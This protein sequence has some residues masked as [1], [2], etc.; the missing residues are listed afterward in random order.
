MMCLNC[1]SINDHG[2]RYEEELCRKLDEVGIKPGK[3]RMKMR[4]EKYDSG[5]AA[6]A[7]RR[8]LY[9]EN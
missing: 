5:A 6:T 3:D 9:D 1:G 8:E 2:Q 7:L 4:S